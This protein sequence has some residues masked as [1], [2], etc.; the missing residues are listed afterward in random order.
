MQDRPVPPHVT[1]ASLP[2]LLFLLPC[3]LSPGIGS[4]PGAGQQIART[5]TL[6]FGV[7]VELVSLFATV[8]DANSR[9]VVSLREEDFVII[10]D[11]VPQ[12]ISQ[13]SRDYVPLSI[14]ILLDTSSSMSGR[15][16]DN[17]RRSLNEFLGRLN[18]GDE[19]LLMTFRTKPTV[20]QPFTRDL[21]RLRRDLKKLEGRGSTA[22]YDS[23]LAA[24]DLTRSSNN[25][26]RAL[27][28]L[29]DGINTYG[30]AQ[31]RDTIEHLRRQGAELF[32]IGLQT[33]LPEDLRYRDMTR[34]V[35]GEL[36]R[37]A[38]GEAFMVEN[39]KDLRIIC[40][41]I[42]DRMHSQYSFG[43]YPSKSDSGNWRS[44]RIDCKVRGLQV[45]SSKA[46]YYPRI[47][48]P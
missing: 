7:E 26:R 27:L 29:S 38:G 25:R 23:I 2:A 21:G 8:L 22:L 46:G 28:L 24:L 44:I 16:L 39:P 36:T 13:F 15:K 6:R 10:E 18:P 35:L 41:T 12:K 5:E 33:D 43:Y 9:P 42:S 48:R 11:G 3:I 37:S 1:R 19:A 20:L 47:A 14:V 17:A 32:A 40:R 4:S 34:A 45:V 30:R 31:L